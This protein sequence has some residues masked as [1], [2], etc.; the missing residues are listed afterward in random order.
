[1]NEERKTKI[2]DEFGL[3]GEG[4]ERQA[5]LQLIGWSHRGVQCEVAGAKRCKG[6]LN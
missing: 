1:M 6:E 4:T 3:E 5:L 2:V